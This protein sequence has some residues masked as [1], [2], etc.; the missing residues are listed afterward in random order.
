MI[1]LK[2]FLDKEI[3]GF[4]TLVRI[5]EDAFAISAKKFN[6]ETGEELAEEV[7]GGNITEYKNKIVE[8]KVQIKEL[9]DFIAKFEALKPQN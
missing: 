3:K 6:A 4:V 5:T 1:D 9:E 7:I 8:L 2:D